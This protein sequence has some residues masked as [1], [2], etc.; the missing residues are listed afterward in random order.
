[1]GTTSDKLSR[2]LQTKNDI[3]SALIDKGQNVPESLLFSSYANKIRAIEGGQ[4]DWLAPATLTIGSHN[5]LA[6]IS[7]TGRGDKIVL[8]SY[9][10]VE[11]EANTLY[12]NNFLGLEPFVELP[13]AI[14]C[15]IMVYVVY[16]SSTRKT[17][18]ALQDAIS[19]PNLS[20]INV[21]GNYGESYLI[22][23]PNPVIAINE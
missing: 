10:N 22:T 17:T 13:T 20:G 7:T 11:T 5:A 9:Y 12:E 8:C 18:V 2:L 4:I 14:S 19:C 6:G 23:G 3:R 16:G 21:K 1:M 15:Q